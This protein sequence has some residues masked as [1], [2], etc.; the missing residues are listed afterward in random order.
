MDVNWGCELVNADVKEMQYRLIHK[1]GWGKP[2]DTKKQPENPLTLLAL[3]K[4]MNGLFRNYN[5]FEISLC[6]C[7][8][9]NG[10]SESKKLENLNHRSCKP[11]GR[12]QCSD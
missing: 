8:R 6:T 5:V 7:K 3:R 12:L 11:L 2:I 4:I 1:N 10:T 9:L